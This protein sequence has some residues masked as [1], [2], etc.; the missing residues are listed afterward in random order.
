[1]TAY[2]IESRGTTY[3]C[4]GITEWDFWHPYGSKIY[5]SKEKAEEAKKKLDTDYNTQYRVV[6]VDFIT[7]ED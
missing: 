7:D 4:W 2:R 3:D 6:E 1:M 5:A